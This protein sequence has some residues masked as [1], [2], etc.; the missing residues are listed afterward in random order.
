MFDTLRMTMHLWQKNV[1]SFARVSAGCSRMKGVRTQ[2]H[3]SPTRFHPPYTN[4]SCR[5]YISTDVH[6]RSQYNHTHHVCKLLQTNAI[7][8]RL[9][10]MQ[11]VKRHLSL[12]RFSHISQNAIVRHCAHVKRHLSP[13]QLEHMSKRHLSTLHDAYTT[14]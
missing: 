8:H 2:R 10:I 14:V 9:V 1:Y 11:H 5:R 7:C 12:S 13:T 6:R 4:A 3:L